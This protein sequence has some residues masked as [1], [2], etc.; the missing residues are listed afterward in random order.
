MKTISFTGKC[1]QCELYDEEYYMRENDK[2][3][4]CP[5]CNLMI[6]VENNK[7]SIL[8]HRGK[9][10]LN[11][12]FNKFKGNIPYQEVDRIS[13]PN[14]NILIEKHLIKYL[15]LTVNQ[16]EKDYNK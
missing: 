1:P 6:L 13:Y 16:K 8:R 2:N 14:G 12:N 11:F 7:A 5:N 15:L 10:Q 4:E 3:L 9:G